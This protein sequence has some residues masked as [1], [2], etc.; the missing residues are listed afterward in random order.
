MDFVTV[1]ALQF[2]VFFFFMYVLMFGRAEWHRG[3]PVDKLNQLLINGLLKGLNLLGRCVPKRLMEWGEKILFQRNCLLQLL[4]LSLVAAGEFVVFSTVLTRYS[5]SPSVPALHTPVLILLTVLNLVLFAAASFKSPGVVTKANATKLVRH[6][7]PSV[8]FPPNRECSTCK[9]PKPA[10]S[11]HCGLCGVCVSRMDHHCIWINNCVGSKN[12]RIFVV[13]LISLIAL[14]VYATVLV[15]LGFVEHMNVTRLLSARY[16]GDDG[17][18]YPV[19]FSI[20]LQHLLLTET[21]MA[22]SFIF[23]SLVSLLIAAFT[24]FHLYLIAKNCTTNEHHKLTYL[25]AELKQRKQP[26]VALPYNKGVW[27]NMRQQL[28]TSDAAA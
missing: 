24:G 12:H 3:G 11:K 20:I 26:T 1:L 15:G 5:P 4:F 10:R 21:V 14:C 8:L 23:L 19:T 6:Y 28:L 17:Q 25:N 27:Q 18:L 13:W 2:G 7:E 9:L 16:R 22:G